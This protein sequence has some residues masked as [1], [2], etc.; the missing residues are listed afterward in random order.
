MKQII[1]SDTLKSIGI[2]C[3]AVSPLMLATG[4]AHAFTESVVG[5]FNK[6]TTG[7]QAVGGSAA[8]LSLS[9]GLVKAMLRS[10]VNWNKLGVV[11][12]CGSL[13]A[14]IGA[15]AQS[16]LPGAS[17]LNALPGIPHIPGFK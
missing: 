17:P 6:A 2:L 11:I 14:V 5:V 12:L 3:M 1:H 15:V 10:E 7:M 9:Y 4:E 13:L 8:T 16:L